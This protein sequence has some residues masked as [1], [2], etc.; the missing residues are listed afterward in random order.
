LV[1]HVHRWLELAKQGAVL[2]GQGE[3]FDE[4]HVAPG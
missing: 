2:L 4:I 1:E 3:D